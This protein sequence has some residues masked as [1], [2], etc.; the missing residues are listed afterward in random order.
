MR[1]TG[2]L[3][4]FLRQK[5]LTLQNIHFANILFLITPRPFQYIYIYSIYVVQYIRI[6]RFQ[7]TWI[8]DFTYIA[9]I[10]FWNSSWAGQGER[11]WEAKRQRQRQIH[12]NILKIFDIRM[13]MIKV[14]SSPFKKRQVSICVLGWFAKERKWTENGIAVFQ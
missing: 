10:Q 14:I 11:V 2:P 1:A 3:C 4:D 5:I 8:R 9:Q 13:E 7:F 12:Q 6:L